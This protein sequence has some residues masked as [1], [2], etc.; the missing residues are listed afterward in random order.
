MSIEER[1]QHKRESNRRYRE[2]MKLMK[3]AENDIMNINLDVLPSRTQVPHSVREEAHRTVF[4]PSI[5]LY[6]VK[7]RVD[8]N[9][10]KNAKQ[11]I[12]NA[13]KCISQHKKHLRGAPEPPNRFAFSWNN[14]DNDE[15]F[16]MFHKLGEM[17]KKWSKDKKVADKWLIRYKFDDRSVITK[18]MNIENTSLLISQLNDEDFINAIT[19]EMSNYEPSQYD[20]F[21]IGTKMLVRL[22]FIRGAIDNIKRKRREGAFW[23]WILK[24]PINLE[25]YQIFNQINKHTIELMN[26]E[27]CVIYACIKYGV[28][29]SIINHMKVIFKN[30]FIS[31]TKLDKVGKECNIRFNIRCYKDINGDT[32]SI[33]TGDTSNDATVVKLVLV[34]GHYMIDK[35]IAISPYYIRNYKSII[36]NPKAKAMP[37]NS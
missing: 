15:K 33:V 3:E 12:G 2:K 28:D 16:Y 8:K 32:K 18:P 25:D 6:N 1:K 9:A 31:I 27:N 26:R 23:R 4:A 13:M 7:Q 34:N 5:D 19:G 10:Y 36:K 37:F 30:R 29:E 20:Y 22:E 14:M 17:F 24:I 35:E 21:P 11:Q